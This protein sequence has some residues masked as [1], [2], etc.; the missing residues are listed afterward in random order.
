[1]IHALAITWALFFLMFIYLWQ[2][3]T[4]RDRAQVGEGQREKLTE[5]A[6]GSRLR[7]VST[8]PNVGLE[9]T[10]CDGDLSRSQML[11]QLKHPGS[12]TRTLLVTTIPNIH[13]ADNSRHWA[14]WSSIRPIIQSSHNSTGR[15]IYQPP[16]RWKHLRCRGVKRLAR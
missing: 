14:E 9:L 12:P 3:E 10:N 15:C 8:E 2:R 11:N 16:Y 13:W 4:E 7:A 1:M 6:A 5:S